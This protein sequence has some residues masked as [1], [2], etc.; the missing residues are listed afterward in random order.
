[1]YVYSNGHAE[2]KKNTEQE[3]EV[4]ISLLVNP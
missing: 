1:M 3:N 4:R 2:K